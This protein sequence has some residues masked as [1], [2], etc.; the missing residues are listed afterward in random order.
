[1]IYDK[2]L[3]IRYEEL[4]GNAGELGVKE[5]YLSLN[6]LMEGHP[7]V[8]VCSS[9]SKGAW[10]CNL[11]PFLFIMTDRPIKPCHTEVT[12]SLICIVYFTINTWFKVKIKLLRVKLLLNLVNEKI[13]RSGK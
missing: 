13:G 3:I 10:S 4:I 9:A 11:P 5:T 1:M 2:P 7:E 6:Q 12:L 8:Q